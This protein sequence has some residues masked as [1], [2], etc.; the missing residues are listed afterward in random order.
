MPFQI[1][2]NDITKMAVDAIVNAANNSLLGGGGVD[3]AIHRAAGPGLL[4]EC[5]TLN[6]CATGE[7]KITGGY[8]LPAKYV[9][10]TVGPVYRDGLHGEPEMLA[11]CYRESLRLAAEHGCTSLAFPLISAGVYGYPQNAAMDIAI[12]EIK[13]FLLVSSTDMLVY[14]VIFDRTA[15][16]VGRRRYPELVSYIDENY[17]AVYAD[18]DAV[19]RKRQ[20]AAREDA[21]KKSANATLIIGRTLPDNLDIPCWLEKSTTSSEDKQAA[22]N[23]SQA[24]LAT[25]LDNI[26]DSFSELLLK[27]IDARGM[28]DAECYRRANIDRRLFAKIRNNHDYQPSKVTVIA[29]GLALELPLGDLQDLLARAGFALSPAARFDVIVRYFVD[30]HIYDVFTINDALFEN[31]EKLIGA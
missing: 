1:V 19:Q 28:T 16:R 7:A 25:A 2:R 27:L 12:G 24:T 30:R 23:K 10:H 3:G 29:L 4:A 31:H 14:L 11:A 18:S 17:V 6:G 5:R 26:E 22:T 13:K 8:N 15:T 9:I 20:L 21:L